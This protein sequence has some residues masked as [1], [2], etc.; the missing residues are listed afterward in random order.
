[1]GKMGWWESTQFE[2][3]QKEMEF[4]GRCTAG[5]WMVLWANECRLPLKT[6]QGSGTNSPLKLQK[7]SPTNQFYNFNLQNYKR[8]HLQSLLLLQKKI[9]N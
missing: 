6:S 4:E 3:K 1:M 2:N 9:R 7:Y 5:K 8:I